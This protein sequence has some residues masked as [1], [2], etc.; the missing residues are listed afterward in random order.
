MQES[1]ASR[2]LLPLPP[3]A[4]YGTS[5]T[6]EELRQ[7]SAGELRALP[8]F[9]VFNEHG[10]IRF[11]PYDPSDPNSGV[12]VTGVDLAQDVEIREREVIVY[13]D[14]S[15]GAEDALADPHRRTKP[16]LGKKLNVR[17]TVTLCNVGPPRASASDKRTQQERLIQWEQALAAVL[18]RSSEAN[19]ESGDNNTAE[20]LSFDHE[21][22]EWVFRVPHFTKWGA[23]VDEE[24]E[25]AG[26]PSEP[27]GDR[28]VAGFNTSGVEQAWREEEKEQ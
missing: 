24:K 15:E 18:E 23:E 27:P 8:E 11:H 2:S 4:G 25:D 17:A 14:C 9:T 26:M 21:S 6:L 7:K 1:A 3:R 20:F 16:D 10:S 28:L 12:D 22:Y 13:G 19:A 5:P